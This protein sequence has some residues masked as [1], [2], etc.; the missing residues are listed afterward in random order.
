MFSG[1]KISGFHKA[2][3]RHSPG[4]PKPRMQRGSEG[5]SQNSQS[6]RDVDPVQG[7]RREDWDARRRLEQDERNIRHNHS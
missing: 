7:W 6:I 5:E 1:I 3:K 4:M 2:A